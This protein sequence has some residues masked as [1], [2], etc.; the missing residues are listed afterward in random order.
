MLFIE[1]HYEGYDA[2]RL[3]VRLEHDR[4]GTPYLLLHGPEPDTHWEAFAAA[5]RAVV[6]HFG[7]RLVVSMGSVPMAVPHTRP[8]MATNHATRPELL[9]AREHLA[10]PDPDPRERRVDARGAAGGVGRRRDGVR[11]A[12]AALRR[13]VRLPGGRAQAAGVGRGRHRAG[14]GPRRPRRPRATAREAEIA[15]Q[16]EESER[17]AR[18][19]HRPRAAVRRAGRCRGRERA[20][21][22]CR[23]P[24]SASCRPP[25]SSARSSSGS[26]PASTRTTSEV[27]VPVHR[28]RAARAARPR[29]ARP[30]TSSAASSPTPRCSGCSAA[31]SPPRRWS[32][33]RAPPPT[34]MSVHSL[35]SY[36]LR[37]G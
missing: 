7:V 6:R 14:V 3:V 23:W 1:D 36:F 13:P 21:A 32:P 34:T 25:R 24:R 15:E 26:W 22:G 10:G 18:A 29:D 16:I 33:R 20:P 31:R 4:R 28:R 30:R 11:R 37:P 35:H 5:V 2:P 19:R 17:G 8:V 9:L 12:R 27:S